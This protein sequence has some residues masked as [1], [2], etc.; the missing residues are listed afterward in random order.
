MAE[1]DKINT[2][3]QDKQLQYAQTL[4]DLQDLDYNKALSDLSRQQTVLTAA[5]KS[6]QQISQLSLFNYIN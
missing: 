4:K 2:L 3:G 1:I 6:F 5:Q